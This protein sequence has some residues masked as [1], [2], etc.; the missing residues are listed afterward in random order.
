M[1]Y[2][3]AMISRV[4]NLVSSYF[5]NFIYHHAAGNQQQSFLA[6]SSN[7]PTNNQNQLGPNMP[8]IES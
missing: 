3:V 1:R 5:P 2:F 4:V 7:V 8:T 6:G